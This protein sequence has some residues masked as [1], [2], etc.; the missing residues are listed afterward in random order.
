M[1]NPFLDKETNSS[2]LI[3]QYSSSDSSPQFSMS[4][5]ISFD[6]NLF[7]FPKKTYN[8]EEIINNCKL[9]DGMQ[10]LNYICG[11]MRE[12]KRH[13]LE[14]LYKTLGKDYLIGIFEKVLNI[15]NNGGLEKS[16]NL[17]NKEISD[18]QTCEQINI[19]NNYNEKKSMGGIF[20]T[21][22]KQDP[23]GKKILNKAARIDYK[24]SKAK[25]N[26]SKLMDK[27]N[28]NNL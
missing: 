23:E 15:E 4:D 11:I 8:I 9:K 27:L 14:S 20:F 3:T 26:I 19:N 10:L 18:G 17:K 1:E 25:K 2:N 28:I 24:K 13:F 21:L 7:C 12:K 16:K 6:N 5:N 22:V